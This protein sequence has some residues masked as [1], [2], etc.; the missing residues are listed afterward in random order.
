MALSPLLCCCSATASEGVA[1]ESVAPSDEQDGS[2]EATKP[3][4]TSQ[5][6]RWQHTENDKAVLQEIVRDYARRTEIG[7]LVELVEPDTAACSVA[8]LQV[9]REDSSMSFRPVDS[10]EWRF[11]VLDISLIFR[12]DELV[13]RAPRLHGI[14]PHCMGMDV[15]RNGRGIG[16]ECSQSGVCPLFLHFHSMIERDKFYTFLKILRMSVDISMQRQARAKAQ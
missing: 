5:E 11:N 1:V 15:Q 8:M 3:L 4:S 7:E 14:S 6:P 9:S 13:R 16:A 2:Q 10:A 12:G